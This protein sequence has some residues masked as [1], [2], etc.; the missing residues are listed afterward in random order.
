MTDEK[1]AEKPSWVRGEIA[2]MLE[3]LALCGLA[4]TQPLLDVTG[5]SPD[6]FLFYG[7][8]RTEILLLVALVTL[9]P[10]LVLWTLGALTGLI[11]PRTRR[12]TH[13]T[14]VGLLVA[15]IAVQFGKQLL[16]MRG[17]PLAALAI[18]VGAGIAY[19][20]W[21]WR[22]PGQLMRIAAVGPLVFVALFAFASPTSAV[23]LPSEAL[24]ARA[25]V[26]QTKDSHP[27]V[28]MLM[29]DEFP[30]VSLLGPDGKIDRTKYPNIAT[31]AD[32]STW[33]RN[34]TGVSGWTPYAMPAMLT[35]KHPAKEVAPHYAAYPDNLFTLL[36]GTYDTD[37]QETI[38]E[39]CPPSECDPAAEQN[40]PGGLKALI[41]EVAGL[42][43]QIASPRDEPSDDPEA[44][45]REATIAEARS[46]VA[47]GDPKFRWDSLDDNQPSRFTAFLDGLT[48]T[49][50]PKLHFLHLLMPHTPWNYLPSGT[51]YEAP[52]DFPLD[53][54]GWVE[55]ARD[56]HLAQ[57]GYTDLLVGKMIS[58]MKQTG[59][60]DKAVLV[61]TADHGVSF[62]INHQGRG[63]GPVE[64]SPEEV[65]WVPLFVKTPAQ[66][67]GA[68]DDRNWQHV[69]LL[70]TVAELA[71]V[72][73]P[74]EVDGRPAS[75]PPRTSH[76]HVYS[77]VPGK[78]VNISDTTTFPKII[79]GQAG[80]H[81]APRIRP[82]LVGKR[83]DTLKVSEA[84]G[85]RVTIDNASAFAD[86]APETGVLPALVYGDLPSTVRDGTPL[87]I[88]VNGTIGA[89][90]QA[91]WADKQGRRFAALV[92]D[93]GLFVPGTNS[94]DVYEVAGNEL[95]RLQ[96]S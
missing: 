56:R 74:W 77:D 88:A 53:G 26:T 89:V 18:A 54:P 25:D 76:D 52:E 65:L 73:V 51:R 71:G 19:A 59:L 94:V 68:V 78:P 9:A 70:P 5:K 61:V 35:G 48:P 55:T 6:F 46:G 41:R 80:P 62:T 38:T 82:D 32:S 64:A 36:G 17:L 69:D 57:V 83:V 87:A 28:V 63:M 45:Y 3:I 58:R 96:T 66:Q 14:T 29:L 30:L 4:I 27:P 34:A 86:V 39:L 1:P 31:L 21:R 44:S 60:W 43:R 23:V 90:T 37:V 2:P 75:A 20:Y 15:A 8:G 7:A 11:G 33:Y 95:R 49:P 67:A 22:V 72:E 93:E 42:F 40:R 24:K 84:V 16:P 91:T 85:P 81:M 47:P 12:V 13:A 10:P 50:R 92:Q 79:S